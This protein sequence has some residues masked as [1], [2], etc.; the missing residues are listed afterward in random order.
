MMKF[1]KDIDA[2]LLSE[3]RERSNF[4]RSMSLLNSS[5][6]AALLMRLRIFCHKYLLLKIF[7]KITSFILERFYSVALF[8]Y[9]IGGGIL[10]PHPLAVVINAESLGDN[11]TIL[12][13]VTIGI[14]SDK[15]KKPR[16]QN[17]VYIG[18]GAKILGDIVLGD[19]CVIGANAVVTKSIPSKSIAYGFPL[20]IVSKK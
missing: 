5:V 16:I 4:Q 18:A 8:T 11:V 15:N 6:Q 14:K 13:G 10:I 3:E 20:K 1:I 19:N 9:N 12:Q 17:N 7:G 2:F